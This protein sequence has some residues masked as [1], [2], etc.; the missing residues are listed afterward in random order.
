M[1][2]YAPPR[3]LRR[4]AE[5]LHA[6]GGWL[7]AAALARDL[8]LAE[9]TLTRLLLSLERRGAVERRR[10]EGETVDEWRCRSEQM[11]V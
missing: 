2:R 9:T 4:V 8:G 6:E 10:L 5:Y 7:S 11:A 1:V 3:T